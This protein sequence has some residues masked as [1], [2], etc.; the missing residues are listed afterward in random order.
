MIWKELWLKDCKLLFFLKTRLYKISTRKSD[1]EYVRSIFSC[2]ERYEKKKKDTLSDATCAGKGL[3]QPLVFI[4]SAGMNSSSC[5]N[6][7][8]FA[9]HHCGHATGKFYPAITGKGNLGR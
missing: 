6:F 5:F 8:I 7:Q 1:P 2:F 3:L 4:G 9:G